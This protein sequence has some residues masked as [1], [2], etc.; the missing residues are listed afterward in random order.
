LLQD[1]FLHLVLISPI[2]HAHN[3]E[4]FIEPPPKKAKS[5]SSKPAPAASEASAP[6]TAPA[7]QVSTASSLSKGKEIP[8]T[9]V[10]I[11]SPPEKPVSIS[12]SIIRLSLTAPESL[13][14]YKLFVE[15]S[16]AV[17]N[18]FFSLLWDF[19]TV[20]STLE[21]F[22]TQFTSLEADKAQL[23]KEIESTSSKPYNAVK[24]VA[25]ACQNADS[26]EEEL[27]HLRKKLKDEEASKAATEAERSEKDSLLRQ[28]I[29]ALLSNSH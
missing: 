10:I 9:A 7:A 12:I 29:L 13:L 14:N 18:Y 24:M 1:F 25:E 2:L 15:N 27:E 28:S 4:G 8:S 6:A 20:I 11:A 22:A 19:R 23:Q 21:A 17:Y 26:L 3:D 16:T 5:S